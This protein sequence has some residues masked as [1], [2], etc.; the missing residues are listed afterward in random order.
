MS[1]SVIDHLNPNQK[2]QIQ[3]L[4]ETFPLDDVDLFA[5]YE[6]DGVIRSAAAFIEED[7]FLYECFGYTDPEYRRQGFFFEL[8]DMS[9]EALPEDSEFLFYTNGNDKDCMAAIHALEAELAL[10][11]HMMELDLSA[12]SAPMSS[13]SAL[14][15]EEADLDGTL[16]RIYKTPYGIVHISVFSSY[17]YLYGL[18]IQELFRGQ[19]HGKTLLHQVLH[20][21]KTK[22][23]LPLRLQVSGDNSAALSLYKKTGFQITET[24]FGYLY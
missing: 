21:L 19:G 1:A 3:S 20:D 5:I 10:E 22:N 13:D 2:S 4:S 11:E 23:P 14:T 9:I 18:E 12:F 15:M 6:I 17:Y 16:T 24:L 7:E 8:L